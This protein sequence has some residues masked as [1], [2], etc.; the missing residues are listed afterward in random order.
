MA[1]LYASNVYLAVHGGRRPLLLLCAVVT[2]LALAPR[3]ALSVM[4]AGELTQLVLTP[5][6]FDAPCVGAFL[7]LAVR[8]TRLELVASRARRWLALLLGLI[9]V[10]SAWNARGC[11][12]AHVVLSVRGTLVALAF[13]ALLV[14]SLAAPADSVPGRFLRSHVMR[15][16]G[17]RAYVSLLLA[18]V[19]YE[20]LEKPFLRLKD[21]LAPPAIAARAAVPLD[22]R[23]A[24]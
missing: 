12:L 24:E 2:L 8:S 23:P 4:G 21:R 14:T 13:G 19:S 15:F 16:L 7:A 20:L 5:C 22:A 1:W 6:R 18:T 17:T 3:L 11:P 10:V 9:L